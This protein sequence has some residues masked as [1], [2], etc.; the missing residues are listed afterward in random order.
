MICSYSIPRY[1]E[2]HPDE[3]DFNS[4]NTCLAGLGMGL[5]ASSA[6]S[7]S[8]AL[9][10]IPVAG[11]EVVRVAFRLGV[12]VNEVSQNLEPRDL[13][14]SPDSWAYVI[15][16]MTA[17]DVQRELDAIHARDVSWIPSSL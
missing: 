2:N 13:T 3:Y 7:L 8:P 5:L 12:L 1:Y 11:A 14:S 6:V 16:D 17:A 4:V 10:D 15:P 9:A